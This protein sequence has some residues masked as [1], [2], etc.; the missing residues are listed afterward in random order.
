[1]GGAS[2][3][4]PRSSPDVNLLENE[5][6][7]VLHFAAIVGDQFRGYLT[8]IRAGEINSRVRQIGVVENVVA[9]QARFEPEPFG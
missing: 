7:A 8:E 4:L 6:Q 5:S 2:A 9:L 1:M 3:P